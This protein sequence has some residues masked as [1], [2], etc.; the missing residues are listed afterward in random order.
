LKFKNANQESAKPTNFGLSA[1]WR[2]EAR[3][4]S[5]ALCHYYWRENCL[6]IL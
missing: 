4:S 6:S 5:P 3:F 2:H 1:V